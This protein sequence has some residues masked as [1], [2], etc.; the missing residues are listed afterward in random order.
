MFK[1]AAQLLYGP[2]LVWSFAHPLYY[3][4]V[5]DLLVPLAYDRASE[6]KVGV[7]YARLGERTGNN[8]HLVVRILNKGKR[9]LTMYRWE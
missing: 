8:D 6:S 2:V 1:S 4:W 9:N 5:P 7:F 3:R